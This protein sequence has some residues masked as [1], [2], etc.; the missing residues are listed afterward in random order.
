M[1]HTPSWL[2]KALG[3]SRVL[4]ELAFPLLDLGVTARQSVALV[5][6]LG[7]TNLRRD[8]VLPEGGDI[9]LNG[10]VAIEN[11]TRGGSAWWRCVV[12]LAG[13]DIVPFVRDVVS[14]VH[15]QRGEWD[16]VLVEPAAHEGYKDITTR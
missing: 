16:V 4:E 13:N 10:E 14:V 2:E 15:R 3:R 7:I 6:A 8:K 5:R 12:D 11:I 9:V 1:R